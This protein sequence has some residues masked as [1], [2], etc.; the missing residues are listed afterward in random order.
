MVKVS[1]LIAIILFSVITITAQQN[2]TT[3]QVS[4]KASVSQRIGLTDIV[5]NYHRPA[6]NNRIVWGGIVPFD[7]VWRAGANENTTIS[8]STDVMVEQNKVSAGTYGL[9][10]IP[11]KKS[12]TIIFSKDN[13]AWGSFFYNEKNDAVRIQCKHDP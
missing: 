6:I 7:Q 11:A 10:M 4:Q 13:A 2:L 9:H 3:P 5:V 1:T 8:F 12:W